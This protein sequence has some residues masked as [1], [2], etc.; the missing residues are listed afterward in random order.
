MVQI[1]FVSGTLISATLGLAD[2]I[3]PRK[4]FTFSAIISAIFT[5]LFILLYKYFLIEMILMLSTGI[6]RG[7]Y[8]VAFLIVSNW[9]ITKIG[10]APG[11][12]IAR[13]NAWNCIIYNN[14][15]AI[16]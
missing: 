5:L 16:Y 8:P 14:E 6:M 1:D 10:L 3:N 15:F 2:K 13:A 4:L 11:I 9:F 12:I 7:I